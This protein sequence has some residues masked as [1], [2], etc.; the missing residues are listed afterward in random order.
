MRKITLLL[1]A[2]C[3]PLFSAPSQ[4]SFSSE[5]TAYTDGDTPP[6]PPLS[7]ALPGFNT[8][9]GSLD[10]VDVSITFSLDSFFVEMYTNQPSAVFSVDYTPGIALCGPYPYSGGGYPPCGG[11]GLSLD[12]SGTGGVTGPAAHCCDQP[13]GDYVAVISVSGPAV[14]EDFQYTNLAPFSSN[15]QIAYAFPAQIGGCQVVSLVS[16]PSDGGCEYWDGTF[17][18][19]ATVTYTY[20]PEPSSLMLLAI[21]LLPGAWVVRRRTARAG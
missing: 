21:V 4:I 2:A 18:V 5:T 12:A 10:A 3:L 9:L 17:S 13:F 8:S 7:V 16:G 15:A 11:S 6:S 19:N 14:T 1:A 20:A